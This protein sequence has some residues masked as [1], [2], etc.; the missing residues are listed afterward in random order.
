MASRLDA[1]NAAVLRFI[2][3]SQQAGGAAT[4]KTIGE[5]FEVEQSTVYLRLIELED[6]GLIRRG[7]PVE[8]LAPANDAL[9]GFSSE[10]L[11]SARRTGTHARIRPGQPFHELTAIEMVGRDK[12]KDAI[13]KCRCS[14]GNEIETKA[15]KLKRGEAKSCGC[16]K[17]EWAREANIKHGASARGKMTPEYSTWQWVIDRCENPNN[18]AFHNYGGRGIG[19]APEWRHDFNAFLAHIGP[20]P[21]GGT[22]ERVDNSKGYIP[23]NVRWATRREQARNKRNN[24]WLTFR[25]ETLLLA[26]WA[27]RLNIGESTIV[28]R[29]K[30]G[31]TVEEA[32]TKPAKP[33]GR[34]PFDPEPESYDAPF[35]SPLP[36]EP[37]DFDT[38]EVQS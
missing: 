38:S 4:Y 37:S 15:N 13:W 20:R 34:K 12:W 24:V 6:L 33:R 31:L 5:R 7:Q 17:A 27:R 14:C 8:V 23:G 32:L 2:V 18:E 36:V 10:Q 9:A 21:N 25:G 30:R 29:L 22:I 28:T 19:I 35:E 3:D 1:A 26:D 11:A 16:K